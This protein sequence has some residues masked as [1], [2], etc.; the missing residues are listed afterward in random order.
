MTTLIRRVL[1]TAAVVA[2]LALATVLLVRVLAHSTVAFG[3]KCGAGNCW[4]YHLEQYRVSTQAVLTINGSWGM[5]L[6]YEL[7][8]ML[9][10]SVSEDRWLAGDRAIYLNLRV[11]PVDDP[12]AAG[13]PL[14][15][16][17]DFQRGQLYIS[18]PLQ[19]WRAPD[20]QNRDPARNWLT[21][22]EFQS[23]LTRLET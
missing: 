15:V 5:Q 21:D 3:E 9:V 16:I 11:K 12:A 18:C 22:A 1:W 14:R 23:V 10:E 19:L 2:V 7:P 6:Q 17:Y 20:Y 8:R 4:G 13:T